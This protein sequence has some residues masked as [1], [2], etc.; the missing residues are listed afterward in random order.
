MDLNNLPLFKGMASRMNWLGERQKV[1]AENV[2][3]ANSPGYVS[4]DLKAP[5]S[6]AELIGRSPGA[7]LALT[8]TN[9]L[10]LAGGRERDGQ[11]FGSAKDAVP[12]RTLD[13][14]AVS[15]EDQ[16]MKVSQ[17]ASDYQLIT[18]LYRQNISMLRSVLTRG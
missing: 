8:R 6:F 4:S 13:G 5:A 7:P 12:E 17:T 10:H 14:N 18:N 2:A 16:M 15:L 3:N 1:L 9:P 11:Q